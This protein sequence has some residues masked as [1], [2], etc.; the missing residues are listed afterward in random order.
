MTELDSELNC[1]KRI[2]QSD[3]LMYEEA[4]LLYRLSQEMPSEILDPK[5]EIAAEL[6]TLG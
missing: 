2:R 1:V 3:W 6:C 4:L 5:N